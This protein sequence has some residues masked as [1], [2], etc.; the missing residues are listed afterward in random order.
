MLLHLHINLTVS[1]IFNT[2]ILIYRTTFRTMYNFVYF[3]PSNS[4]SYCTFFY[5]VTIL[6][7]CSLVSC[8]RHSAPVSTD[9]TDIVSRYVHVIRHRF[10]ENVMKS[11]LSS[12]FNSRTSAINSRQSRVNTFNLGHLSMFSPATRI[13]FFY[14]VFIIYLSW[15]TI[16][17]HVE[18]V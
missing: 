12:Y 1:S 15:K 4:S 14:R 7:A 18:M 17:N 16:Q 5:I 11:F 9:R 8:R 3:S 6:I 13:S 10:R 2:R